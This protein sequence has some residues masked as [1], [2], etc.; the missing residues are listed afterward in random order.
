VLKGWCT[1]LGVELASLGIQ[2]FGGMGFVEETGAAQYLRDARTA[3][4]YEGTTGIQAADLVGRKLTMDNGQEMAMLIGE[5]RDVEAQ[6]S[7]VDNEDFPA[8]RECLADGIAAL[9]QATRW[10]LQT[11][12]RDPDAAL[13]ASVNYMMLTGYVCGGWQMARAAL[14]ARAK[15]ALDGDEFCRSKI[16]TGAVLC[17]AGFAESQRSC[18]SGP[19]RCLDRL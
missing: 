7:D 15:L 2:V 18:A 6:L 10:A 16:A 1:E 9:E 11:V 5:M 13:A 8:I 3:T 12:G 17:R 14:A 4:I 19:E